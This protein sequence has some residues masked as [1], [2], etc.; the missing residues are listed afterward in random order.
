MVFTRTANQSY[1]Q[2][3]ITSSTPASP[4][5]AATTATGCGADKDS[6]PKTLPASVYTT[7]VEDYNEITIDSDRRQF[8]EKQLMG[9][10][11]VLARMYHEHHTSKMYTATSLGEIMSQRV[12]ASFNTINTATRT[13]S[14]ARPRNGSS[15]M[16]RTTSPRSLR[17]TGTSA[18]CGCFTTPSKRFDG[19]GF[20]SNTAPRTRSTSTSIGSRVYFE[21]TPNEQCQ[22]PVGGFLL[23]Y[24]DADAK[25]GNLRHHH[26]RPHGGPHQDQRDLTTAA[27]EETANRKGTRTAEYQAQITNISF[28]A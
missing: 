25:Q 4:T 23:G 11:K 1:P 15:S 5:G 21:N 7:L 28:E 6:V 12:W 19:S 2:A 9:A 3:S 8:P 22:S 14:G 24:C 17:K 10:E 27:H 20:C 18:V 13:G 26:R 16:T